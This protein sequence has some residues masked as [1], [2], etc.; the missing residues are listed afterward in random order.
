MSKENGFINQC[1]LYLPQWSVNSIFCNMQMSNLEWEWRVKNPFIK[2]NN[3]RDTTDDKELLQWRPLILPFCLH[4][5]S[6]CLTVFWSFD[7]VQKQRSV[8][9]LEEIL[10]DS[11]WVS[12][13][14]IM[15]SISHVDISKI[16]LKTASVSMEDEKGR[17]DNRITPVTT[18]TDRRI[19]FL[20]RSIHHLIIY[21]FRLG[22]QIEI[23]FFQMRFRLFERPRN[24]TAFNR[25]PLQTNQIFLRG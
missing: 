11:E 4:H 12:D 17:S 20:T 5:L 8:I 7:S 10:F 1:L 3:P 2:F 25:R 9:N 19:Q 14:C 23:G 21:Y 18:G 13:I 22:F 16:G 6:V 15:E 24:R